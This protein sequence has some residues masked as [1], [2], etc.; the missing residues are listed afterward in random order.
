MMIPLQKTAGGFLLACDRYIAIYSDTHVGKPLQRFSKPLDKF[1]KE[2]PVQV[3]PGSSIR[4]PLW[5]NCCRPNRH[6]TGEE[7]E[8]EEEDLYLVREDGFVCHFEVESTSWGVKPVGTVPANV[9]TAF[10]QIGAYPLAP[11]GLILGG[12]LSDGGIFM[13]GSE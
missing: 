2:I 9:G 6:D 5:T 8:E 3:R 1:P 10:D 12:V 11:D 4:R 13:V 7:E